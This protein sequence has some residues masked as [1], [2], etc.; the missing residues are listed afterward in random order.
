MAFS[1]SHSRK[2]REERSS[3]AIGSCRSNTKNELHAQD[4][5]LHLLLVVSGALHIQ[6]N[7]FRNDL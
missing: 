2:G 6:R 1:P 3:M 5:T 7:F 4:R